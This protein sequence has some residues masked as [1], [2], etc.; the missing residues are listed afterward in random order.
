M[1]ARVWAAVYDAFMWPLERAYLGE[2]RRRLLKGA[3]G[4]V[5][6]IGAGT[7]ASLEHYP[8]AAIDAILTDPELAMLHR[9]P[10]RVERVAAAA[11]NLPFPSRTFDT[12]ISMLVLCTVADP[13]RSLAEAR[14]VLRPGGRLLLMEHVRSRD[15][16]AAHWQARLTPAWMRIARGCHLDRDTEAAIQRAGFTISEVERRVPLRLLPLVLIVAR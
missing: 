8:N 9:V 5:L 4:R 1:N 3:Q 13:G 12:V 15:A 2:L 10:G 16:A 11:E 14:R 6:E 7:G